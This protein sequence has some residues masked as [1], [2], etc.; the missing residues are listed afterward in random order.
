MI[1]LWEGLS[2]DEKLTLSLLGQTLAS[3]EDHA[4]AKD[5]YKASSRARYPWRLDIAPLS[6]ALEALFGRDMLLKDRS[7]TPGYAFRIDLW[8]HWVR[9]MHSVWQVMRELGIPFRGRRRLWPLWAGAAGLVA[10]AGIA[11]LA[12]RG[13]H[14]G[15]KRYGPPGPG[16]ALSRISLSVVPSTAA[17]LRDGRQVGIGSYDDSL[18]PRDYSFK[19][20]ATGYRDTVYIASLEAGRSTYYSVILRPWTG[21]VRILTEP[22]GAV[23]AVDGAPRG[24]SPMTVPNLG[25][26]GS[27]KLR[28]TLEGYVSA[29]TEF[30]VRPDTTTPI[31]L[32][33]TQ[34]KALLSIMTIPPGARLQVDGIDRGVSN[35]TL[36][37]SGGAHHVIATLDGYSPVDTSVVLGEGTSSLVLRLPELPRSI[38]VLKGD[39]L[40]V[41]MW[42]DEKVIGQEVFKAE[43]T[44]VAPGWHTI[45]VSLRSL[46]TVSDSIYVE[47]GERIEYDYSAGRIISREK[48]PENPR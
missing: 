44:E 21:S 6:T 33:L 25:V 2:R 45:R 9:R 23:I 42:V 40:A 34:S 32:S 5:L 30:V 27:H 7:A 19:F 15:T 28:A 39:R 46:P 10:A 37:L 8:R 18:S 35:T 3:P 4:T 20:T 13:E 17:I 24:R 14:G 36:E 47:P 48:I 16:Q 1:F 41:V 29:D 12:S 31:Q 26:P 43:A 22:A 11:I 38:L